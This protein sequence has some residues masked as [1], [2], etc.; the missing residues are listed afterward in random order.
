MSAVGFVIGTGR[1]G[2]FSSSQLFKNQPGVWAF[3]ENK[4]C[5]WYA[6]YEGLAKIFSYID[7]LRMKDGCLAVVMVAFYLLPYVDF[8]LD[9]YP[10]AKIACLWRDKDAVIKSWI[11]KKM[12]IKLK[13]RKKRN[14]SFFT[15]IDSSVWKQNGYVQHVSKLDHRKCYPRYRLPRYRAT[16]RYYNSYFYLSEHFR[17]KYPSSFESFPI[18]VLND[19]ECQRQLFDFLGIQFQEFSHV[20][21]R[22]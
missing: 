3:H 12:T 8:L 18:D 20:H 1:C 11:R 4:L 22:R 16:R 7:S 5:G 19:P 15:R 14:D 21:R 2:T 9:K 6:D 13:N 17:S 10:E